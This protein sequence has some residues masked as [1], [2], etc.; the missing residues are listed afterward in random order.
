MPSKHIH[1]N[2]SGCKCSCIWFK[3]GR[4]P[5]QFTERDS[6]SRFRILEKLLLPNQ[7]S[8]HLVVDIISS[9][10]FDLGMEMDLNESTIG[11]LYNRPCTYTSIEIDIC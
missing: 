7:F 11:K 10:R 4:N 8:T 3:L 6:N 2:L 1:I 9:K 5:I